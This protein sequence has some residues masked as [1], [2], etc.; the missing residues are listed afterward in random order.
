MRLSELQKVWEDWARA[1]PLWAILSDPTK[2]Q[3]RWDRDAF[4]STGREEVEAV[5][6]DLESRGIQVKRGRCLDF[7]CGVGRL[8]QALAEFFEVCDG[9]DISPTMLLKAQEFNI[10]P[11]RCFYRLNDKPDLSIY[12]GRSFDFIYSNIVLQHI[13]PHL[14]E[15]YVREFV[16]LLTDGG[17]AMFQVPSVFLGAS[18]G[19]QLPA[20][21]HRA[22]L[23]LADGLPTLVSGRRS[24]LRVEIR[25]DS[26]DSWPLGS[27]VNLGNHWRGQDG[28]TLLRLDDGRANLPKDLEPGQTAVVDLVI[29]APAKPGSYVLELDMVEEGVCWFGDRGSPTR[30]LPVHVAAAPGKRW[31]V[32]ARRRPS[33]EDG[34]DSAPRPFEMHALPRDRVVAA[35]TESGGRMLHIEPYNP[36]GEGW[37][38]YRYYVTTAARPA[39]G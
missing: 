16:R 27:R 14:S 13:K 24:F 37:E 3:R 31:S 25:N 23:S 30:R 17:V 36:S 11:D 35:V 19:L 8:T 34:G 21:A 12:P 7:G 28:E 26:P 20:G 6:A 29:Q 10:F 39:S 5:M 9:V 32:L 2:T 18:T 1:D 22:A 38:S 33:G 4:F 15:R